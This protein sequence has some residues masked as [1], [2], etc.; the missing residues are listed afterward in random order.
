MQ[1]VDPHRSTRSRGLENRELFRTR[2]YQK[3]VV[4]QKVGK[5]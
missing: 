4:G 5:R 1:N 3:R 2:D